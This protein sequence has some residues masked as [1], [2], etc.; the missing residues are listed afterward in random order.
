MTILTTEGFLVLAGGIV[1]MMALRI[2]FRRGIDAVGRRRWGAGLFWLIL[3][4]ILIA[5]ESVPPVLVGYGLLGMTLLATLGRLLPLSSSAGLR[6]EVQ[7]EAARLGN[8]LLWPV[9]LVPAIAIT[10]SLVLPAV[11]GEGWRLVEPRQVSQ[12]G[13]GLGAGVAFLVAWRWTRGRAVTALDEG[14]RL[15][16]LLGWTLLLPPMLAALGGIF[17][18]AGVGEVIARLVAAALPVQHPLVAV[19]AYCAGMALFTILLGNA[20]AAF[21]VITLGV[22]LPFIVHQHGGQPAV[23]GALGMLSGYCGTLVTPMAAN[24]NLV[25]VRLL[26]LADDYAVMKA[27]APMAAAIWVFNVAVMYLFVYPR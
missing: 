10:A 6:P 9:L 12:V 11:R 23:M 7:A 4:L 17:A 15:L 25:P 16:Q 13:I 27:Q 18:R 22:G 5:G 14:G 2:L 20:F 1:L 26:E 8:R 24:F 19:V 21:P 3:A